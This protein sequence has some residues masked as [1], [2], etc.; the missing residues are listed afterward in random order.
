MPSHKPC[1]ANGQ[2]R[3]DAY[4]KG[5]H[6][7]KSRSNMKQINADRIVGDKTCTIIGKYQ[8]AEAQALVSSIKQHPKD[9]NQPGRVAI[10]REKDSVSPAERLI[11]QC[12]QR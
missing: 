8:E 6:D 4:G 5:L 10:Q 12:H 3:A 9:V 11:S 7:C 2:G 1:R